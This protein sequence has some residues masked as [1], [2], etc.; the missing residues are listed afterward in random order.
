MDSPAPAVTGAD[1]GL[2]SVGGSCLSGELDEC[3]GPGLGLT[4]AC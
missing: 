3:E 2:R 4:L 1:G